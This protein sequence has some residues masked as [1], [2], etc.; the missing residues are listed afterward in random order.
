LI[1]QPA[2]Y[3]LR[4]DDLCPT[5]SRERWQQCRALIEEFAL[6]PTLAIVPD[7]QD[8]ELQVSPPDPRFWGEMRVMQASGATIGL[9]GYRHLCASRGRSLVPWQDISEFAGVPSAIQRLWI[10]EGLR[11]LREQDLAAKVWVAPRHG[12]DANTLRVLRAEGIE[13]VSDGLTPRAFLREGL[14][15]LPQ[16][17]W[18]PV[19]KPCGLWTICVHPNT[20]GQAQIAE[21]RA[22]LH[23]HAQQFT[24]VE[25]VLAEG[26][27]LEQ[28]MV[29]RID[30]IVAFW[31]IR[32]ARAKRRLQESVRK[33]VAYQ[34]P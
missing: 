9:H 5:V 7:N 30:E 1:S 17:L 10:H 13:L 11:M 3:L 8:P 28:S 15:W 24:S 16:Q 12:F 31:R 6:Q 19:D 22:F 25:R 4:F 32:T 27:P 2:Q 14:V 21:L 33:Q 26:Q 23:R 34:T 29:E 18:A 20:A